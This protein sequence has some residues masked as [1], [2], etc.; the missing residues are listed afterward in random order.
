MVDAGDDR[1]ADAEGAVLHQHG[2]H[3]AAALLQLGLDDGAARGPVR[4]GL[5]LQHFGLEQDGLE[6]LLDA[7]VVARGDGI[8]M[9]SPPQ[10]SGMRP[11]SVSCCFTRSGLAPGLS[12]LL[13]ATMI[14]TSAALAWLIASTVC[15]ITP[16]SAATT[17][18][19]CR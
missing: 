18:T 11:C 2:G 3:R 15:G 14:G 19:R 13:M 4:V 10:S 16:S 12:I 1:V 17:R 5:E 6:Q 8:I 7:F 9:V